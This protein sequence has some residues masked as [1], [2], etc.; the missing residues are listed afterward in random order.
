[1]K[2]ESHWLKGL[3]EI[4]FKAN[5]FFSCFSCGAHFVHWSG[6]VLAIWVEGHF[7]NIPL[8]LK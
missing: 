7:C 6:A 3:G 4:A 8:K 1:M 2:F 5:Y